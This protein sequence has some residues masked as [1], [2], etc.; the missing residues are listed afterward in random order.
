MGE[1]RIQIDTVFHMAA[2][3]ECGSPALPWYD[4]DERDRWVAAHSEATG[5]HVS[6]HTEMRGNGGATTVHLYPPLGG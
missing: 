1:Q 6:T 4:A 5:H 2:C 3:A